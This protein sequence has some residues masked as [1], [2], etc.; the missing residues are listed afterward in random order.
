MLGIRIPDLIYPKNWAFW[1]TYFFFKLIFVLLAGQ[2]CAFHLREQLLAGKK[3]KT[4]L[5]Y[6][7]F[8]PFG[9]KYLLAGRRTV[10]DIG[11]ATQKAPCY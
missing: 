6:V 7:Y 9:E 10:Q 3:R 5:V 2:S 1:V 11:A 8:F 4:L